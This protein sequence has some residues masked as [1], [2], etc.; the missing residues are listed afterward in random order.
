MI[1]I[2]LPFPPSVNAAYANGGNRR[3]RHK[4][5]AYRLWEQLAAIGIK[6]SH[7]L[8]LEAYTIAIALRA[9]D[10]RARDLGNYEKCVSDLLVAHGVVK[11]DSFCRR[12]M[13]TWNEGMAEEC[14]VLIHPAEEDLA[15]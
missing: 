13:M 1:R 12:L 14:V 6:D 7:R 2:A 8:A 11:D 5:N 4:T 10:K 9:P 3:G 15:A